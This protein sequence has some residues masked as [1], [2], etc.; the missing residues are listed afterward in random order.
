MKNLLKAIAPIVMVAGLAASP[1]QAASVVKNFDLTGSMADNGAYGNALTRSATNDSSLQVKITG[2]QSGQISNRITSAYVGAYS[3]GLGVTG[4]L[5]FGGAGAYHQIDNAFGYTDFL[6]LQFNRAV[7]LSSAV[8]N[9][10]QMTGFLNKDSDL[11]FYNAGGITTTAWDSNIDLSAYSTLPSTWATVA[12]GS[13]SGDRTIG[14]TGA[15]TKWLLGAA[16]LPVGDRDDGFKIQSLSVS[17][18]AAVPEPASW[19]LMIV[20]FGAV[21]MSLRRRT[22]RNAKLQLA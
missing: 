1:A 10:Y 4:N 19:A 22:S 15:S 7:T 5:D 18:V 14:A 3:T 6:L 12:G 9:V 20:G 16:F 2:W 17:E 13:A 21:G 8:L 11:A